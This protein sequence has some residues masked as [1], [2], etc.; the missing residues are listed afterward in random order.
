M[1]CYGDIKPDAVVLAAARVGGIAANAAF[2][3]EYLSENLQIELNV[4]DAAR[5][6]G[7]HNLVFI[8]SAAAYPASAVSPIS[9]SALMTG[10][11]EQ[12]HA[13]YSLAKIAGIQYVTYMRAL[14]ARWT[15]LM[16]TNIYGPNDNFHVEWSHVVPALMRRFHEAKQQGASEIMLWGSG[17]ARREFLH[18]HD[19]AAACLLV[20]DR[21]DVPVTINVGVGYD[22]AIAELAEAMARVTGFDGVRTFDPSRPDGVARRMLDTTVLRD[23][24]WAPKFDLESGLQHTYEWFASRWPDVRV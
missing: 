7:V 23:L 21:E 20:L 4:L 19:L 11:P 6:Q 24:G 9:E 1:D 15:A 17:R 16:P 22:V 13:G 8:G 3:I 14:G 12:A 18:S 5:T 2:P 10:P